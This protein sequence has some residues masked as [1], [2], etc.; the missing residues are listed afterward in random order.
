MSNLST[1]TFYCL[2]CGNK[3]PLPRKK[4]KIRE[5]HHLKQ[6]YC[7]KCKEDINHLEVREFDFDFDYDDFMNKIEEGFFKD[8]EKKE[9]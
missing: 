9:G 4:G 5:K 6:I 7:I 1:S 8:K 2:R 3:V